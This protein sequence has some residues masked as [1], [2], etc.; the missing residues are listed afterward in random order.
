[1]NRKWLKL[2]IVIIVV[3]ALAVTAV[4]ASAAWPGGGRGQGFGAGPENSLIAIA[5]DTLGIEPADLI[6]ELQAGKTVAE[7]ATEQGVEL[8]AIVDTFAAVRA[9][10]LNN[11]VSN[12]WLTQ[13]QAD[14][15]LE[16]LKTNLTERLS[17]P[18]DT[19]G[20]GLGFEDADGDGLCDHCEE[21][22]I[23]G[24]M[25][26]GFGCGMGRGMMERG[27]GQGMMGRGGMWGNNNPGAQNNGGNS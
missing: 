2:G 21:Y 13:E 11:A 22:G 14:A 8:S 25:G 10:N 27:M 19:R 20:Y 17:Q 18:F 6:A 3:L 23:G 16:L 26:Q 5:A 12:G 9:E 1:M 24:G 7:V 4:A 15:R